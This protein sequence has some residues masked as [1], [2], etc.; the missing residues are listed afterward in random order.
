MS[1]VQL[2]PRIGSGVPCA[3][4]DIVQLH[5]P[6]GGLYASGGDMFRD[7]VFGRDSLEAA[8][9]LLDIRPEIVREVIHSIV[10]LQGTRLAPAGLLSNEEEVGR[11][12]HEARQLFVN[13][14]RIGAE[15]EKI[16]DT[17]ARRWGGT[18]D[19]FTYY[20]SVDATPLFVRLVAGYCERYGRDVLD[21]VVTNKDDVEVTVGQA[22][23]RAVSWIDE[24]IATSQ[25]GLLEFHRANPDGIEY[26]VWKDGKVSLIHPD[27]TPAEF[28]QPIAE[29]ACQGLAYDALLAGAEVFP[30]H[31]W[32]AQWR[33]RAA[34]LQQATLDR[35]WMP[36]ENYF[37]MAIDR[38]LAGRPRQVATLTTG[39]GELLDSRIFDSLT[40]ERRRHF[41]EPVVRMI[42]SR[43]FMTSAGL[44]C[45]AY[46]HRRML[47]YWAYQGV[48]TSWFKASSDVSRGLRKQG[49]G[50][51][52][53]QLDSRILSTVNALGNNSEFVY[54][55]ERGSR[56]LD[57]SN[58]RR[59]HWKRIVAATN[60]ADQTQA[61]TV[62][63]VLAIKVRR[64]RRRPDELPREP[65]ARL[66]QQQLL[67]QMP[68]VQPQRRRLD[69]LRQRSRRRGPAVVVDRELGHAREHEVVVRREALLDA[70]GRQGV[71]L[72]D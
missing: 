43:E 55:D 18:D 7:A 22:T 44:R 68:D 54:V 13:G 41:V 21:D 57:P 52:A 62:T 2:G 48:F 64:G 53:T 9:D 20:G 16:L 14:E 11:V 23:G 40:P 27:G 15:S 30:D 35:F 31:P 50:A 56:V 38:D 70:R 45:T 69:C 25:L 47:D 29:L 66:M 4:R 5:A 49:F 6:Q 63:A 26:Q 71:G 61:W 58:S 65:W 59:R 19:R 24:R 32:A 46:R 12:H 10:A 34:A 8:E 28:R 37:A 60:I 17:L 36:R 51:L 3:L 39:A 42:A 72:G 33:Q 67:A 1:F